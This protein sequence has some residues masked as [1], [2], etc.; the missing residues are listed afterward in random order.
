MRRPPTGN[1]SPVPILF[2]A[3]STTSRLPPPRSPAI[4]SGWWKP[5]T[6]PSALRRASSAP[7]R[8]LTDASVTVSTAAMNS[9]PFEASRAAAVAMTCTDSTFICRVNPANLRRAVSAAAIASGSRRPPEATPL[10]RPHSSF[11]LNSGVIERPS[12]S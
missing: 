7:D 12:R 10:T 2:S 9:R 5:A 4:P 8:I 3:T 1:V 6:I 11:S